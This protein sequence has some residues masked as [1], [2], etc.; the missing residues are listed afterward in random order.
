MSGQQGP[1]LI[2][3]VT[4]NSKC[5]VCSPGWHR[6]EWLF[7]ERSS[8][9]VSWLQR[10]R[11]TVT[12]HRYKRSSQPH[13]GDTPAKRRPRKLPG[14]PVTRK[15]TCRLRSPEPKGCGAGGENRISRVS[16]LTEPETVGER[17]LGC[18]ERLCTV[19][20]A[21]VRG[22]CGASGAVLRPP[23]GSPRPG[24]EAPLPCSSCGLGFG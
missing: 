15:Q 22:L 13:G 23:R 6:P 18:A 2:Y 20:A 24:S 3:G 14:G 8:V 11:Q 5:Y 17:E 19:S 21:N 7:K 9:H 1:E 10:S 12:S 4:E 16:K